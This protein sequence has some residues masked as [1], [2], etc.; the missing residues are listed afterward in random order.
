LDA[1]KLIVAGIVPPCVAKLNE[2]L[3]V[4]PAVIV[5]GWVGPDIEKSSIAKLSEFEEPPPGAGL[6][7][8][9][10][11][12]PTE[13]SD[14]AGTVA[15]SVV[16]L[17]VTVPGTETPLKMSDAPVW[18]AVPVATTETAAPIGAVLGEIDVSVGTGLSIVK[19]M[20]F[21][22]PPPGC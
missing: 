21:D 3:A 15:V 4:C 18:N 20:V 5:T 12:L 1:L 7:T 6:E 17:L 11:A 9:T 13:A 14:V 16:P 22:G 19:L 8:V 2:K 10:V